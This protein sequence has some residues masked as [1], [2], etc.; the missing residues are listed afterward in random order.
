MKT[1]SKKITATFFNNEDDY[2]KLKAHWGQLMQDKEL[3]KQLKAEH[4]II[5]LALMGKDWTKMFTPTTNKTKLANGYNENAG[6]LRACSVAGSSHYS[7][8]Y[9]LT[10]FDGLVSEDTLHLIQAYLVYDGYKELPIHASAYDHTISIIGLGYNYANRVAIYGILLD[11]KLIEKCSLTSS[12]EKTKIEV[13]TR[14]LDRK[15]GPIKALH[16][17]SAISNRKQLIERVSATL[18]RQGIGYTSRFAAGHDGCFYFNEPQTLE[19]AIRIC[20]LAN[21][22]L[23]DQDI[24]LWRDMHGSGKVSKCEIATFTEVA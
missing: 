6:R 4:H 9:L 14:F 22:D 2:A 17:K 5:Y 21:L 19:Q 23:E 10:P 20:R 8:T 15:F 7:N 18:D 24:E 11:G 16:L 1:L 13:S 3:R 12:H